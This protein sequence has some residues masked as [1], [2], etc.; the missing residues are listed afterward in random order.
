MTAGNGHREPAT[1]REIWEIFREVSAV[2]AV[3]PLVSEWPG[4]DGEFAEQ[5]PQEIWLTALPH[6]CDCAGLDLERMPMMH[7]YTIQTCHRLTLLAPQKAAARAGPFRSFTL[8]P[9]PPQLFIRQ[10]ISAWAEC[11]ARRARHFICTTASPAACKPHRRRCRPLTFA[12]SPTTAPRGASGSGP[13][14][15][16][17]RC[18]MQK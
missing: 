4:P 15:R 12:A 2:P 7:D 11:G 9:S 5:E 8:P 18:W 6:L 17:R 16:S 10:A 14:T 1:P 3:P 13:R